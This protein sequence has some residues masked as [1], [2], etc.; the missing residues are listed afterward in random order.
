MTEQ[1][2]VTYKQFCWES[3]WDG[4]SPICHPQAEEKLSQT[5]RQEHPSRKAT[6]KPPK[7]SEAE[8]K[9]TW[10]GKR[11]SLAA[12]SCKGEETEP[13]EYKNYEEGVG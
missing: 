2:M 9:P 7:G 8:C 11:E 1:A 12:G 13:R 5:L 6:I 10:G 3:Q 4:T